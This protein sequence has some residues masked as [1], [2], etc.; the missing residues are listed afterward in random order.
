MSS[1][2][3]NHNSSYKQTINN[4]RPLPKTPTGSRIS[5]PTPNSNAGR[6][7]PSIPFTQT[8]PPRPKPVL[9]KIQAKPIKAEVQKP[10]LTEEELDKRYDE[11]EAAAK[12][13]FEEYND[14]HFST[15]T[16]SQLVDEI[17][18]SCEFDYLSSALCSK[19]EE[20][21]IKTQKGYLDPV[22]VAT[23]FD[24]LSLLISKWKTLRLT[25]SEQKQIQA[26]YNKNKIV[27]KL[28]NCRTVV[29]NIKYDSFKQQLAILCE[30][31]EVK[32]EFDKLVYPGKIEFFNYSKMGLKKSLITAQANRWLPKIKEYNSKDGTLDFSFGARYKIVDQG[33]W[34]FYGEPLAFCF[35]TDESEICVLEKSSLI[36]DFMYADFKEEAQN[37]PKGDHRAIF[38]CM[39]EF[40]RKKVLSSTTSAYREQL[41]IIG[42]KELSKGCNF[43]RNKESGKEIPLVSIERNILDKVGNCRHCSPLAL[44]LISRLI[45]DNILSFGQAHMESGFVNSPNTHEQEGHMWAVWI[46]TLGE[47]WHIDPGYYICENFA[48]ENAYQKLVETYGQENMERQN[49]NAEKIRE[50]WKS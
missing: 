29:S 28:E 5:M 50:A 3:L 20:L 10:P 22:V 33:T 8:P 47:K 11:F 15:Y 46:N 4:N 44:Y 30:I 6:P 41:K 49:Y 14:K 35:G 23:E 36:L 32:E 42:E 26:I 24:F 38:N 34:F 25:A 12:C 31:E 45:R 40:I 39:I 21:E 17:F 7:L 13:I 19:A 1:V 16:Q 2:S 27:E 18:M 9:S 43:V 37:K 48:E